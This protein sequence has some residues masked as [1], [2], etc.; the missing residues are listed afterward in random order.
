MLQLVESLSD[1]EADIETIP[2]DDFDIDQ[3]LYVHGAE[4]PNLSKKTQLA[5]QSPSF[6]L[7]TYPA[8]P[9]STTY[10]ASMKSTK[11]KKNMRARA[12]ATNTDLRYY[13]KQFQHAKIDD[14]KSWKDN[15]VFD[16]VDLRKFPPNNFVTGRWVLTVKRDGN[17][18]F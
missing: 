11:V 1:D 4:L 18:F 14:M 12:E 15:D 7:C 16:L 9:M 2:Y 6:S 13:A 8:S 5:A 10:N 17:G 3:D